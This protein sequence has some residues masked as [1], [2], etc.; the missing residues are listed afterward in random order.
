MKPTPAPLWR[1]LDEYREPPDWRAHLDHELA[2]R[3]DDH[4][5]GM[6]RRDFAR[7]MAAALA[8]AGLSGCTRQS[9]YLFRGLAL[10]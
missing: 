7:L 2:W 3:T 1:T 8:M 6:D 9:L 4:V 5:D 10:T